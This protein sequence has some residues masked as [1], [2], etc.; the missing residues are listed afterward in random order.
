MRPV[1]LL[2]LA[3]LTASCATTDL[4]SDARGD[5]RDASPTKSDD[6]DDDDGA[7]KLENAEKELRIATLESEAKL[8]RTER[9]VA[10]SEQKL[11]RAE[12]AMAT[13]EQESSIELAR[14]ELQ[15]DQSEES[16]LQRELELEELIAM[17]EEDEFAVTTKELVIQRGRVRYEFAKRSHELAQRRHE[18]L[19]EHSMKEERRK[20]EQAIADARFALDMARHDLE[21]TRMEIELSMRRKEHDVQEMREKVGDDEVE[22]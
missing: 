4:S 14:A 16:L 15:L 11:A 2:A 8:A 19:V 9:E 5:T 10:E 17:Y 3:A 21:V 18:I 7:W 20:H 1:I 13:W 22:A 12:R 6:D